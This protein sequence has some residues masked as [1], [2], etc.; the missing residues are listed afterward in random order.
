MKGDYVG[1]DEDG[2]TVT[3]KSH[4][5]KL[6]IQGVTVAR[7]NE[8]FQVTRLETWLGYTRTEPPERLR[9]G[10]CIKSCL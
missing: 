9:A 8:K 7:L 4:N 2:S 3:I 1:K 10:F 5:E 6:D